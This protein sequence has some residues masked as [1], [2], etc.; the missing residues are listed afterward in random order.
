MAGGKAWSDIGGCPRFSGQEL[1]LNRNRN[2]P[3]NRPDDIGSQQRPN[4]NPAVKNAR[5]IV[6]ARSG[7]NRRTSHWPFFVFSSNHCCF[8]SPC[9]HSKT[10]S[11]PTIICCFCHA[12]IVA[13][14]A[15][16]HRVA[17]AT[18]PTKTCA[19]ASSVT[20]GERTVAFATRL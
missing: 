18:R 15:G 11:A 7:P 5:K 2:S 8:Q 1:H 12:A 13:V 20:S 6:C 4:S 19:L 10:T 14:D 3:T 16:R 17:D 9:R